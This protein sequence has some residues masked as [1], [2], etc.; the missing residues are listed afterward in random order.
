MAEVSDKTGNPLQVSYPDHAPMM[1]V[2]WLKSFGRRMLRLMRWRMVGAVPEHPK[3]LFIVAPH[4]S[5]WDWIIGV[6]ALLGIG[7]RVT[8]LVKHS[9][10]FWPLGSLIRATGG[11]PI[12]RSAPEGAV[13]NL[14]QEFE[15][16]DVLYYGIAPEGTR[17]KVERWKTGF[18]RVAAATDLALVFV[19]IDYRTK[20]IQI[21]PEFK[22]TG[23]MDRDIQYV[24]QYFSQFQGKNPHLQTSTNRT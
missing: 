22:P 23:E 24:V 3:V 10:F 16:H 12:V 11:V 7:F 15:S 5:N 19:S 14:V 4:T 18:L 8:Y 9:L 20:T 13:D 17:S 2:G 6:F 1:G 21:G